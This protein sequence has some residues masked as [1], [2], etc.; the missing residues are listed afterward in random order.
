MSLR[1]L[2]ILFSVALLILFTPLVCNAQRA[3]VPLLGYMSPGDIP[4][5]DNAFLKGLQEQGYI[6]PSEM[7]HYDAASWQALLKR[8]YFEGQK[9]RI[10]FRATGQHFERAPQLASELIGLNV[11][12]MFLVPALLVKAGQDALQRANKTIP[13]V[14][15]PEF[16]PVGT[17]I[18]GS[19]AR[20]SGNTTGIAFVDPEL[21]AKRL[22]ILKETFPRLSRVAYLTDSAWHQNYSLRSK[23]AMEAAARAMSIRLETVD[24]NTPE[25]LNSAFAEIG[26]GRVEAIVVQARSPLFVVE[27]QRIGDFAAKHRLPAMYGDPIFVEE[28]GLMSYGASYADLKRRCAALVAKILNGS[29]PADMPV[30]Q[31]TTYKLIINLKTAKALGVTVPQGILSRADQVIR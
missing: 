12:V 22:E 9:I 18:V 30:E 27:R 10:E 13:I 17:G 31:P 19:L 15:G 28:G 2:G 3:K 24:A 14:F 7:P 23:A 5:Y 8:G 1:S 11:D 4:P 20:P 16:D 25:D 26:R 21:D 6:L 29:K